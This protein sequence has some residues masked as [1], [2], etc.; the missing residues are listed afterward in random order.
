[1]PLRWLPALAVA[2]ALTGCGPAH[3]SWSPD[4]LAKGDVE[5]GGS[6]GAAGDSASRSFGGAEVAA[7]VRSSPSDYVEVGGRFYTHSFSTFGGALEVR[8]AP[9][10][11]PVAFSIDLAPVFGICCGAGNNTRY[12][13]I[14]GGFDAGFTIGGRIG[15][16]NGIAPYFAPHFQM[17]WVVPPDPGFPALLFFPVGVDIPLGESP[18]HLRPEFLVTVLL[19]REIDPQARVGGA[20]ALAV[21]GPSPKKAKELRKQR[22]RDAEEPP[23]EESAPE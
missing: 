21:R 12:L 17:V 13:A 2:L 11:R 10:R 3:R 22:D 19:Y 16:D 1:M 7:W 6:I 23:P 9:V 14:G 15:G 4:I 5:V 8:I 18:L 20:I